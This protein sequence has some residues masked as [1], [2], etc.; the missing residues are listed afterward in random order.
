STYLGLPM[1]V[2]VTAVSDGSAAE[3]AGI[4]HGD[5]IIGIEDEAVTSM[6]EL[7]KIKNKYKAGDTIK[8]KISRDGSDIDVRLTLQDANA[9][10]AGKKSSTEA[11]D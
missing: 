5:V 10:K 11:A 6:D 7:N 3:E 2:Y 9:D 8:L 1:G 4:K